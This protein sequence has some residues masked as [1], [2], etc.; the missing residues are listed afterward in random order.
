MTLFQTDEID[1]LFVDA[2]V[3]DEDNHLLFLSAWGLDTTLQEFI[4]KLSL[5]EEGLTQ[6]IV[7]NVNN[8]RQYERIVL[9]SVDNLVK[10]TGRT[11]KDSLFNGLIH[12]WLHD[13]LAS[14]IDYANRRCVLLKRQDEAESVFAQRLWETVR[15]VC[16]VPLLPEWITLV[17]EFEQLGWIKRYTGFKVDAVQL[18]FSSE[19]VETT[20]SQMIQNRQLTLPTTELTLSV[21][22][23]TH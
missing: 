11:A 10:H 18:D 14:E 2:F 1:N 4:A 3:C 16:R 20:L 13:R 7:R 17:S 5:G 8:N 19:E 23:K 12:L 22:N 9:S 21:V 6:M 15:S